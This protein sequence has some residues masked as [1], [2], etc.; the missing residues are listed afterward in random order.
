MIL[1][2]GGLGPGSS[3]GSLIGG[4]LGVSDGDETPE[5]STNP[6][7]IKV[8]RG[9]FRQFRPTL[10]LVGIVEAEGSDTPE[11]DL[12]LARALAAMGLPPG[13]FS[14]VDDD[15]LAAVPAYA[16]GQFHDLLNEQVL[17]LILDRW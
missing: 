16:L 15:D 10:A 5:P 6:E 14:A 17:E 3:P 2:T 1:I 8:E 13:D 11:F 7:R 12:A 9:L 4:G